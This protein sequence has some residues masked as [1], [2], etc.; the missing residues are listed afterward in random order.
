MGRFL[1]ICAVAAA[2]LLL[3]LTLVALALQRWVEGDGIRARAEAAARS[4]LGVPV[5]LGKVG[6]DLWPLPAVA[7]QD[8]Q[9]GTRPPL[10]LARVQARPAWAALLAGRLEVATLVVHDAVLPQQGIDALLLAL[11]RK[12]PAPS[13]SAPPSGPPPGP[14]A[15]APRRTVLQGVRWIDARGQA[16]TLDASA[17]LD[18]D[19]LPG[20]VKLAVRQGRLEGARLALHRRADTPPLWALDATVGG[21]TVRGTLTLATATP[22]APAVLQGRLVTA[23]VEVAALLAPAPGAAVP[24]SGKLDAGTT[25]SARPGT[26]ALADTLQTQTTFNVRGAVVHGLDLAQ[27]VRTV[28]ISRG[29]QTPLDVLSGQV[30]TQGRAAQLSNLAASSG[31]LAASGNVAVSAQRALSGRITVDLNAGA[32]GKVVNVAVGVPLMVGGT[33]DAPEVSLTRGALVGAAVGTALLPGAGTGA[34]A[35]LGDRLGEGIKGLFGR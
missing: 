9:V 21:G 5:T 15:L 34:G 23:N 13:G 3:V 32:A 6:V 1:K 33:L 20:E 7:L 26:G 14:L 31:V 27:A 18:G 16:T 29:G 22:G 2:V 19:G 11:G 17:G 30:S 8:V 35:K 12:K 10:T 24:L 4:A 28:G 25:L